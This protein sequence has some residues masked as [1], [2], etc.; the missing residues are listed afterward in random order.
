MRRSLASSASSSRQPIGTRTCR[1][2]GEEERREERRKREENGGGNKE[3]DVGEYWEVIVLY[4]VC[5]WKRNTRKF[6][7]LFSCFSCFWFL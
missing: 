3:E 6:H 1:E 5:L 4:L 2:E 7:H